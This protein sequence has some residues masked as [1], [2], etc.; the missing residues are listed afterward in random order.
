MKIL[1][2]S[3]LFAAA[4]A[5]VI[6]LAACGGSGREE[7]AQTQASAET[8]AAP[9]TQ[10]AAQPQTQGSAET[11]A[12]PAESAAETQQAPSGA[13]SGTAVFPEAA[14]GWDSFSSGAGGWGTELTLNADG[15]FEGHFHDSEMGDVGDEY[16]N[17]SMYFCD[18]TGRFG[19]V[20]QDDDTTWSM[21]LEELNV[22]SGFEYDAYIEDGVRWVPATPYGME[23]EPGTTFYL[24]APDHSAEGFGEEFLMW[25]QPW[26][27]E[28]PRPATF[29]MYVIHNT[30][31]D[32]GFYQD[33]GQ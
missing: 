4:A 7:P 19:N 18:F 27:Y 31:G 5:M 16:P 12:L 17:G 3:M 2:R 20:R 23:A 28:D 8:M 10:T 13:A 6:S 26:W 24:Y 15:T 14:A 25:I 32:Y 22:T 33:P 30:T 9:E 29:G 11:Q 21:T 1:K